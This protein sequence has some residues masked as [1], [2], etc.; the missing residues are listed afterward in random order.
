MIDLKVNVEIEKARLA[1]VGDGYTFVETQ[2]MSDEDVI[3]IWT[4][5]LRGQIIDN[6]Y[7]GIRIGLYDPIE[8][9][10]ND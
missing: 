6:Y 4:Y 1:L 5:R 8:V 3:E 7:K 10:S 9:T 2:N